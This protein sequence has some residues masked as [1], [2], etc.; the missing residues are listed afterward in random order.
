[1]Q[2]ERLIDAVA[3]RN[4]KDKENT[5][6]RQNVGRG[7]ILAAAVIGL[8][9]ASPASAL[10]Q[11][12]RR[13]GVSCTVCHASVPQLN[14]TGYKFRVAGYR[15]PDEIGN[16]A[17][18]SNYGDIMSVRAREQY[19]ITAPSTDST[20]KKTQ[21]T[22]G[23]SNPGLG[24]YPL[25]GAFGKYWGAA[26][27]VDFSAGNTAATK[28]TV[29]G[30]SMNTANL[31]ATI[32]VTPDSFVTVR[33]GLISN[34]EGYG[35]ADRGVGLLSPGW[36]PT[37]SQIQPGGTKSFTY[38]GTTF[39]GEGVELGYNWKD[40]HASV[41]MTNGY[42]S[43]NGSAN[44]GEDNHLKDF[45]LYVNQMIGESALSAFY[46][47]GKTGYS[48]DPTVNVQSIGGA[49]AASTPG[50]ATWINNYERAAV[51]GTLKILKNEK[52]S[53]LAGFAEG[54]DHMINK[55]THNGADQFNSYGMFAQ[56]QSVLHEHLTAALAYGTMRASTRAAGNRSSDW[57]V[58]V[59]VPVENAKFALDYQNKRTQNIGNRDTITNTI[60]AEWMLHY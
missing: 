36:K 5:M 50:S 53:L 6:K 52:L 14:S 21:A 9:A 7:G 20:G 8:F 43:F 39:S 17:K 51:Y 28:G 60:Q 47:N 33:S 32:P 12:A 31:R 48:Y 46:Y 27:E 23:F 19:K 58:S 10:P 44:Q 59:A 45:S 24:I 25:Y 11:W 42:N 1:L 37:A 34:F 56:A 30:V 38:L 13:Y 55:T 16:D 4:I 35:A 26:S 15:M 54:K 18:I 2:F 3:G 22:N 41:Q 29:G 57:T 40:T 49:E